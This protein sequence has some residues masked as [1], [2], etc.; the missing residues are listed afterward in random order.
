MVPL[1][2]VEQKLYS[3]SIINVQ[4]QQLFILKYLAQRVCSRRQSK[5]RKPIFIAIINGHKT[6]FLKSLT[7][8]FRLTMFLILFPMWTQIY[9]L[10]LCLTTHA[11]S[12][13]IIG[14]HFVNLIFLACTG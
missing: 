11:D 4:L 7:A 8:N 9:Q 1:D 13:L 14:G 2:K 10:L 12:R 5:R 6:N 3:G